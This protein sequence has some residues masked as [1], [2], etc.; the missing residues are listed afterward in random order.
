VLDQDAIDAALASLHPGWSGSPAALTR[1][2]EFQDFLTA[3]EFVH[4]IA[5]RCEQLDHHP[6]LSLRWRWVDVSLSTH[7]AGGVTQ[8]DVALAEQVD[9]VAAQLPTA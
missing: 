7:S 5:P 9:E 8:K 3:V 1:S 2:I 4:R 6:D